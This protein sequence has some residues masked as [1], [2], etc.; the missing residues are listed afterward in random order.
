MSCNRRAWKRR[1]KGKFHTK[2]HKR[3]PIL[4]FYTTNLECYLRKILNRCKGRFSGILCITFAVERWRIFEF[5]HLDELK[6]EFVEID[7]DE[8]EKNQSLSGPEYEGGRM[9]ANG[10]TRLV[11]LHFSRNRSWT[12]L[13]HTLF[14]EMFANFYAC[15][16][17]KGGEIPRKIV[18]T[19]QFIWR[20]FLC[21]FRCMWKRG[22]IHTHT[23]TVT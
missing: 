10:T 6:I 11:Q 8:W 3:R 16:Y 4:T 17:T 1:G 15:W 14:V 21:R 19:S 5:T 9:Y 2:R 18:L 12:A 13:F 23:H 22:H 7:I 20:H